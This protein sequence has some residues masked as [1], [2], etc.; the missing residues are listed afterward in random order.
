[1]RVSRSLQ[2]V[3]CLLL[4]AVCLTVAF[5]LVCLFPEERRLHSLKSSNSCGFEAVPLTLS[6]NGVTTVAQGSSHVRG[7]IKETLLILQFTIRLPPCGLWKDEMEI[8]FY[9][10][11]FM[12]AS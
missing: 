5:K 10:N 9:V 1:M 11:R 7:E 3:A 8:V 4:D 12:V 6:N 2:Q